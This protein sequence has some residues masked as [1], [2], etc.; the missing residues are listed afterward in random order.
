MRENLH[1]QT[2]KYEEEDYCKSRIGHYDQ[3]YLRL[4]QATPHQY[5]HGQ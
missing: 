5:E 4:L 3:K 2:V 1:F